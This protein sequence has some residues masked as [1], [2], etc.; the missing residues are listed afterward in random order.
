MLGKHSLLSMTYHNE[1]SEWKAFLEDDKGPSDPLASPRDEP[2]RAGHWKGRAVPGRARPA[3]ARSPSQRWCL[4]GQTKAEVQGGHQASEDLDQQDAGTAQLR[5][6]SRREP[7]GREQ[8]EEAAAA[9]AP[10]EPP[11][12]RARPRRQ[13]PQLLLLRWP[14][15]QAD[16]APRSRQ[17]LGPDSNLLKWL[18]AQYS[19]YLGFTKEWAGLLSSCSPYFR[20]PAQLSIARESQHAAIP[21]SC[22]HFSLIFLTATFLNFFFGQFY[23]SDVVKMM[24]RYCVTKCSGLHAGGWIHLSAV[25]CLSSKLLVW[26]VLPLASGFWREDVTWNSYKLGPIL[27]FIMKIFLCFFIVRAHLFAC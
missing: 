6:G 17:N 11:P 27:P 24:T 8:Q 2:I 20:Q 9:R 3:A 14:R 12:H 13:G 16:K 23:F 19:C 7:S 26:K 1:I 25:I 15:A 18:M 10:S 21:A 22:K 5:Q 4:W